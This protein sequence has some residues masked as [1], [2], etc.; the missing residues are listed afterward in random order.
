M[1]LHVVRNSSGGYSLL[2]VLITLAVMGLIVSLLFQGL[3]GTARL[4]LSL[5]DEA[6]RLDRAYL[7]ADWLRESIASALPPAPDPEAPD[8]PRLPTFVGS[9]D[10]VTVETAQTLHEPIGLP[11][12]IRWSFRKTGKMT[13]LV[14]EA[15]ETSWVVLRRPAP[16]AQFSYLGA[17][18]TWLEAWTDADP[19]RL[20]AVNAFFDTPILARPRSRAIEFQPSEKPQVGL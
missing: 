10:A 4:A 20:V 14:Y 17:D 7:S 9:R 12:K 5:S 15:D 8:R 19:P 13:E 2:E 11:R 6:D 3:G 18:G 16:E 1:N